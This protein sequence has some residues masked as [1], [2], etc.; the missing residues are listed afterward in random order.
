MSLDLEPLLQKLSD[1]APRF[2]RAREDLEAMVSRGRAQDYKG[3]MQ[4]ARLVLEA[5]LR[6]LVTEELKQTPGKAMLDELV[7]KFRQQANAGIIPTNILA[8]MGTVQ[9]WGNLSA[10]DHAGSLEDSGVRVGQEEVVASL[11]SM[12][13]ILGWYVEKR[14]LKGEI[15]AAAASG[16]KN[17]LRP[18]TGTAPALQPGVPVTSSKVPLIA[19]GV[20]LLAA[21]AVGG[22]FATRP[23]SGPQS[24]DPTSS[25]PPRAD[26]FAALDAV[27]TAWDEPT[28]PAS[29]RRAE[30]VA[31]LAKVIKDPDKL[32]LIDNPSPEA[33][34]LT[35][36]AQFEAKRKPTTLEAAL[37]CTGFANAEHLAGQVALTENDLAGAQ[38][39]FEA[40]RAAAPTWLD[41]R[42]KL[43]G[44]LLHLDQLDTAEKEVE[45]LIGA[46]VDYAP[47]YLLRFAL[48]VK[49]SD[50]SG[51]RIDLC[52]AVALGSDAARRKAEDAKIDC[53]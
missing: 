49:R 43:A 38:K 36:R 35:A 51:A 27:Y 46:K 26:A 7:T 30:D 34:Y 19:G 50:A 14:G 13:A 44:V 22:Y 39:R 18:V 15:S 10:H 16:S 4:N 11:N 3:V 12:V 45:G 6:S 52:K 23:A 21:L 40:A 47:A 31:S 41:N 53:P 32:A 9:A 8:H 24:T 17:N 5:I 25:N 1:L 29:C 48:K 28:P 2:G 42:A 37:K 33:A 20:A